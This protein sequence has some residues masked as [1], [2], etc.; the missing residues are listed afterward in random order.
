MALP[1]SQQQREYNNFKETP[2]GG[3]VARRVCNDASDPLTVT[4]T[5]ATAGLPVFLDDQRTPV[6]GTQTVISNAV[7]VG[8]TH[9]L[10][11]VI[12]S[13]R[14]SVTYRV[15]IDATVIGSGRTGAGDFNST[16][17]WNPNRAAAAS[18][19][20]SVEVDASAPLSD[21][22]TYVQIIET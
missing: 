11:Q 3:E 9:S 16:F 6:A 8:K 12:V 19:T 20:V 4:V 5:G 7:P 10:S 13:C 15:K 18:S 14:R 21:V 2:V 1:K 22:E 17:T